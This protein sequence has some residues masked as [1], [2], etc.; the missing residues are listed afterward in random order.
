MPVLKLAPSVAGA[1]A[2]GEAASVPGNRLSRDKLREEIDVMLA[3]CIIAPNM[4]PDQAMIMMSGLLAR[5]VQM[6]IDVSRIEHAQR[7]LK[8]LR[9]TEIDPLLE[10]IRDQWKISS[11]LITVRQMDVDLSR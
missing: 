6:R 4:E 11:R 10:L 2:E 9:T 8:S 5:G 7:E 1:E 3:Q